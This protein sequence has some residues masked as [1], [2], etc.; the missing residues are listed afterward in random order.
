M[1]WVYDL[2]KY[3][4]SYS[5]G[6]DFGRHNLKSTLQ[7]NIVDPRAVRVNI[8]GCLNYNY[9]CLNIRLCLNHDMCY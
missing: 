2:W 8:N 1:L 4:C 5:A 9:G 7:T 3:F 6:M